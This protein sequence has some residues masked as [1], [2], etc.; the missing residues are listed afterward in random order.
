VGWWLSVGGT[1]FKA[2]YAPYIFMMCCLIKGKDNF[3]RILPYV[4]YVPLVQNHCFREHVPGMD[5]MFQARDV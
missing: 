1:G 3:T 2:P 5:V 4:V